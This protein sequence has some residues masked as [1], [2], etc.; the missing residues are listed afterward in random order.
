MFYSPTRI[1]KKNLEGVI[2]AQLFYMGTNK[3]CGKN[4]ETIL[5]YTDSHW[6]N[7]FLGGYRHKNGWRINQF[8]PNEGL[9]PSLIGVYIIAGLLKGNQWLISYHQAGLGVS[10]TFMKAMKAIWPWPWIS[11]GKNHLKEILSHEKKNY[12][13]Y[14]LELQTTSFFMVVSIGWW[15]KSLHKKWLFHQTSIKKWLFS[16]PGVVV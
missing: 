9:P 7:P 3:K 13:L 16:V 2:F 12:L 8:P 10:S 15:T 14:S 5:R 6:M 4:H 11:V 1:P